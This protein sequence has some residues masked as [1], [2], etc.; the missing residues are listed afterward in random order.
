M[1]LNA[2]VSS[3]FANETFVSIG[4][5]PLTVSD[6]DSTQ[7][8]VGGTLFVACNL[9]SL[10]GVDPGVHYSGQIIASPPPLVRQ[11]LDLSLNVLKDVTTDCDRTTTGK[12]DTRDKRDRRQIGTRNGPYSCYYS[13]DQT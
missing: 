7:W 4:M 8:S 11:M 12:T 2:T 3:S 1:S 10:P 13:N 9:E 5:N 6:D